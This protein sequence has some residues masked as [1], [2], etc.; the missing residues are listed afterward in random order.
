MCVCFIY[1]RTALKFKKMSPTKLRVDT[2]KTV[3]I[4]F[5]V[6]SVTSEFEKH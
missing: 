1:D 4:L 2:S 5:K 6:M 3:T